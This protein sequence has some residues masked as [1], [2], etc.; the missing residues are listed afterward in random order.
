MQLNILVN[1]GTIRQAEPFKAFR[2]QLGD[3]EEVFILDLNWSLSFVV[4]CKS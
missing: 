3:M 1:S 2:K 4:Y